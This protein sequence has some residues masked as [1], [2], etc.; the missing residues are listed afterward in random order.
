[1]GLVFSRRWSLLFLGRHGREGGFCHG[2]WTE[3]AAWASRTEVT[4]HSAVGA[5]A[6][7]P[8]LLIDALPVGLF[9]GRREVHGGRAEVG[10]VTG[11]MGGP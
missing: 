6:S 4:G 5:E 11:D 2:Q 3:L 10:R 8:A 1:M 9:L 7:A